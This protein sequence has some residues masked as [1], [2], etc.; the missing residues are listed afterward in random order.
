MGHES[1]GRIEKLGAASIATGSAKPLREGDR[2]T[3]A[4]SISCG[5]C[6]YCRVKGQPT[7]V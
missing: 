6:F 2:V 4:S 7:R 1:A 3:W 5:E